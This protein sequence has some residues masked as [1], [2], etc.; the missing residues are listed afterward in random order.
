MV[1]TTAAVVDVNPEVM[2]VTVEAKAVWQR[3][4]INGFNKFGGHQDQ[5]SCHDSEHN[6]SDEHHQLCERHIFVSPLPSVTFV[7]FNFPHPDHPW[8]SLC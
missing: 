1:V 6:K 8:I 3:N 4:K 7:I 5:R 2:E